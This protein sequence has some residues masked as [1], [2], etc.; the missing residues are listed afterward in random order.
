[1]DRTKD[2]SNLPEF[3]AIRKM[4]QPESSVEDRV[5][6]G[7]YLT[8]FSSRRSIDINFLPGNYLAWCG[9]NPN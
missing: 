7:Q 3:A 4:I 9:I 6:A 8:E 5:G 1:M 2:K